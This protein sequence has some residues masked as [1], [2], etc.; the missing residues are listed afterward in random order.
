[1]C[2]LSAI[3]RYNNGGESADVVKWLRVANKT[4]FRRGPDGKGT[5]LSKDG[6]VGLT[7][8]R[9]A[10]IDQTRAG[11]QP[12][13]TIDGR[14]R[15][16]FNGE[17]YNYKELRNE[18]ISRGC[19]FFSNSDTE[20][21]LHL[22]REE[23][24]EF[25]KRL[26][27]MYAF[28]LWDEERQGLLLARDPLGIKPLYFSD[29]GHAIR[30]ASQ[31]KSILAAGGADTSPEPAGHVG[32]FLW[33]YVPEP[34]TLY[35]GIRSLP[36]GSM[37]WVDR[38]GAAPKHRI[39]Y[40]LAEQLKK[41]SDSQPPYSVS[42]VK[43]HLK[44]ALED[45]VHHHLVS[46]VPVGI[47]LSS[48]MDS[49]SI[50]ALAARQSIAPLRTFT[51]GFNQYKG[52]PND[53][54][55]WAEDIAKRLH[56]IHETRW[57]STEEF[58]QE[59][60]NIFTAMDQPSIDGINTYFISKAAGET[61]LKVALS[62]LGGDELFGGYPSFAHVPRMVGLAKPIAFLG[63]TFRMVTAPVLRH[64]TSPKFA[65]MLE[66]GNS[67][68]GAYLLRRGLFMP[69]ELP[70]IL[71][72]D[73]VE[74]G[75]QQLNPLL[76]LN[77]AMG[78][79]VCDHHR[80]SALETIFYMRNM[81]LRD[82]D[83]AGMAHSLEV[84]VPLVD[85]KLIDE[86]APLMCSPMKPDKKVMAQAA[87]KQVPKGLLNRSKTGFSFPIRDYTENKTKERGLRGWAH[88]VYNEAQK[89]P[90]KF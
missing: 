40:S 38:D 63:K 69:W 90:V 11:S 35:K 75:W 80:V 83:W 2:G 56:C 66:Y 1:M 61:G 79:Q 9:L 36:A 74:D 44:A 29:D 65:G 12:M 16:V 78:R 37:L 19:R 53:E 17:I 86:V 32:F 42:E 43:E 88:V 27:G 50:A 24:P 7:H 81:L 14:L 21:L 73:M 68:G 41:A 60:S 25:V 51:L 3:F 87:W 34:F 59:L 58:V 4:L 54:T 33:G 10:V 71:D 5:W 39:F 45:S 76:H 57:L 28:V 26:R 64:F 85:V 82:T 47:F 23:G 70:G 15:I 49:T 72:P 46:D 13:S 30:V 67:F 77:M 6:T 8:R 48:G 22:Y 18:L 55:I 89:H 20:V 31:V 84:R 52:T 62:G